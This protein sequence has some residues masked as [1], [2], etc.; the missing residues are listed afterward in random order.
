MIGLKQTN[1]KALW[2]NRL[3]RSVPIPKVRSSIPGICGTFGKNTYIIK[4][5][6]CVSVSFVAG[7]LENI[8]CHRSK[9]IIPFFPLLTKRSVESGD[10]SYFS[11]FP[12]QE[13]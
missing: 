6:H 5:L 12:Q 13:N 7:V 2:R 1:L 11:T 10:Y 9:D 3:V 4:L 8:D